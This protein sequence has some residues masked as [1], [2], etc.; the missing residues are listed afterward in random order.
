MSTTTSSPSS[1]DSSE[2]N[3]QTE[4]DV[5]NSSHPQRIHPSVFFYRPPTDFYHYLIECNEISHDATVSLLNKLLKENNVKSKENEHFFIYQ[6]KYDDRFYQISCEIISP[7]I[8]NN[9]L[10]KNFLGVELQQNMEQECLAFTVDQKKY[11]EHHLMQ[12]LS[13]YILN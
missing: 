3:R 9:C 6:Q 5:A 7:L 13:Q 1:A 10:S 11:L 2:G 12:Y 4:T 8:V